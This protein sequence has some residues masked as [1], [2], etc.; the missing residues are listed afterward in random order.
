[1]DAVDFGFCCDLKMVLLLLGKQAASSKHCCPY[2]NGS[3]PWTGQCTPNTLGSLWQ[4][5]TS[6][7]NAGS[8]L[9]KAKDHNNVIHPPL[10]TGADD[11]KILGDIFFFQEHHVFTGIHA[12][13]VKELERNVFETQAEGQ[14]F[15][16]DW[17]SSPGVNISR[18]VYHGS[19]S[20][21]G[22]MAHKFIK[23]VDSLAAKLR[24]SLSPD[25]I[26]VAEQ[27]ILAFRQLGK[28]VESCF[29]QE[30][31]PGY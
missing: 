12:K 16:D 9:K 13:L 4:D 25:K 5:Y 21:V 15:V 18:T 26:A 17:M 1:M 29:G 27:Y 22:N 14:E 23:K 2:C 6:Y 30:L 19:A 31:M 20:F 8:D 10:V 24:Q 11:D 28:V 3:S 7:V